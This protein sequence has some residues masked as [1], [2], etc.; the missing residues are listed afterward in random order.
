MRDLNICL[1]KIAEECGEV[2]QIACKSHRYGLEHTKPSKGTSNK[3][4]LIEEL[5]DV[6]AYIKVLVEDTSSNIT[7]DDLNKR[8]M[9]K[10]N[11][12]KEKNI[13]PEI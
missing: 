9:T 13:V 5:G 8:R 6:L 10:Y 11:Y 1:I 4:L 3:E 12:I 7:Y 2:V